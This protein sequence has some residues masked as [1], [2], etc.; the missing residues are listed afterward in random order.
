M[1]KLVTG[2]FV[3]WSS[4]AC[5]RIR[6]G[7]WNEKEYRPLDIEDLYEHE[8][9]R[10]YEI[11]SVDQDDPNLLTLNIPDDHPFFDSPTVAEVY[12]ESLSPLEVLAREA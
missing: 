10:A 8:T 7:D 12:L 6:D 4:G 2:M 5:Q 3:H 11:V 1:T 9:R